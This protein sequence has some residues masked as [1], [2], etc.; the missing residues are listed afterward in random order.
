MVSFYRLKGLSILYKKV[1]ELDYKLLKL[2]HRYCP[3]CKTDENEIVKAGDKLKFSNKKAKMPSNAEKAS[4]RD[5][6]HGMACVSRGKECTLVPKDHYGPIPGV[7][8]GTCWKFRFQVS[9]NI[10][11]VVQCSF[12]YRLVC[13]EAKSD[14]LFVV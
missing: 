5:W 14:I 9:F 7:E 2:S 11:I 12:L 1:K 6:G 3:S 10:S 4:K 8:V 13:Y